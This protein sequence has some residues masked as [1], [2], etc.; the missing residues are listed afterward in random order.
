MEPLPG[1]AQYSAI[2]GVITEDF[3][4]DGNLDICINTNDYRTDPSNGR[5]DALNGLVLKRRR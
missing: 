2:N 3:D 5:Y 4:G 1:I